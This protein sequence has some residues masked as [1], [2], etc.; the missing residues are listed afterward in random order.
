MFQAIIQGLRESGV[1][2]SIITSAPS[3]LSKDKFLT[4]ISNGTSPRAV[5][6]ESL[7]SRKVGRRKEYQ[8]TARRILH[9]EANAS[10]VAAIPPLSPPGMDDHI[11]HV[12][13]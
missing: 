8:A 4:S 11:L 2:S 13:L 10:H 5:A 3:I 9:F 12:A 1:F 6:S 7:P